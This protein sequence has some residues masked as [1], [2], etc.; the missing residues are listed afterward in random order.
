L[1]LL[2]LPL[3]MG[4][5]VLAPKVI[6]FIGGKEFL[7]GST[8][9]MLL[10]LSSLVFFVSPVF[11]W[12]IIVYDEQ[13]YLPLVYGSALLVDFL[14]NLAVIPKYGIEGT[15]VVTGI[16]ETVVLILSLVI[17]RKHFRIT[18]KFDVIFRGLISAL[19][20]ASVLLLL[21]P[22]NLLLLV[23][24]G[25]STYLLGLYLFGVFK[26]PGFKN[27]LPLHLRRLTLRDRLRL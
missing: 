1:M 5:I 7:P 16:S 21:K 17:V 23:V 6:V 2:G 12:L 15:A 27:L 9:F 8:S 18:P 19:I 13:R 20:M 4:G 10:M 22:L 11:R 25:T 26:K 24:I 3:I 14:L